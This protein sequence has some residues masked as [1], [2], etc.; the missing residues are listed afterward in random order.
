MKILA[1]FALLLYIKCVKWLTKKL[2]EGAGGTIWLR[3]M[4]Q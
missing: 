3:K 2:C 4:K 1:Y